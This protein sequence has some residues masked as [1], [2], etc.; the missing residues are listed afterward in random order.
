MEA[1]TVVHPEGKN[2]EQ[3]FDAPIDVEQKQVLPSLGIPSGITFKTPRGPALKQ[4]VLY[5]A[6]FYVLITVAGLL[7]VTLVN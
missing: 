7:Y 4:V 2:S 6:V 1:G 3:S 5:F